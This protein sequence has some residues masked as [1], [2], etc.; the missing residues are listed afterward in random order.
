M[1]ITEQISETQPIRQRRSPRTKDK[2][3][4]EFLKM[5]RRMIRAAGRRIELED[6]TELALL[7]DMHRELDDVIART[8]RALH[9]DGLSWGEIGR[10]LGSVRP[11]LFMSRQAAQQRW[12]K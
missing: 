9:D 6:A 2:D 12:G 10:Q 5:M 11:E 1:T 8:A 7:I 3:C 4:R